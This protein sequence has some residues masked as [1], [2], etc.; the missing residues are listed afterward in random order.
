MWE[1]PRD[2]FRRDSP[3]AMLLLTNYIVASTSLQVFYS[4][5]ATRVKQDFF[6]LDILKGIISFILYQ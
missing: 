6:R 2:S 5:N 1:N 3:T 4:R